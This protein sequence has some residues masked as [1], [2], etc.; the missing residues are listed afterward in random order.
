MPKGIPKNGVNRG[1]FKD[2]DKGFWFD[3]R[4]PE[5]RNWLPKK[6]SKK[7]IKKIVEANKRDTEERGRNWKGKDVG[8]HGIHYWVAKHLG[9]PNT[10]EHCGKTQLKSRQIHW[11]NKSGAYLREL[12]DWIRLCVKCHSIFD[13]SWLKRKRNKKGQWVSATKS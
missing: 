9:R 4:R 11:A 12:T 2:G 13:R 6:P 10:C 3:K 5:I 8:Y 1:W 7:T